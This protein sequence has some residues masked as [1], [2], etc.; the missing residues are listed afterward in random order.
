LG[1]VVAIIDIKPS[2]NKRVII[3]SALDRISR[4]GLT[5]GKWGAISK[6]IPGFVRTNEVNGLNL[7]AITFICRGISKGR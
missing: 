1:A 6:R 4:I 2:I 3:I 5:T 7:G